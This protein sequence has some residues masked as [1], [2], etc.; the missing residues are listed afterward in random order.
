MSL[1]E[2]IRDR[3]ASGDLLDGVAPAR[4]HRSAAHRW[5]VPAWRL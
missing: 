2:I 1:I 4:R 3:Y 5:S